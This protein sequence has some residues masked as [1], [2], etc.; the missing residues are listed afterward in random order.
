VVTT[1]ISNLHVKPTTHGVRW[2]TASSLTPSCLPC[3]AQS[4]EPQLLLKFH[5]PPHAALDG[6][7]Q[8]LLLPLVYHAWLSQLSH[9]SCFSFMTH[10][11]RRSMGES[12]FSCSLSSAMPG[13]VNWATTT[14]LVSWPTTCDARWV[15]ASSLTPSC[16]PCLAQ[17]TEPQQLLWFHDLPH[18]TLNGWQQL[19][20]LPLVYHA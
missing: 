15:T 6:R 4:T 14:A 2:V 5:D 11:M 1:Y 16:L 20:L 8:L 13:S 17:S 12:S 9:N 10:H 19:L 3:L 7:Q 18:A